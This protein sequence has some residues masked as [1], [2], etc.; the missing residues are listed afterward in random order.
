MRNL[1][2]GLDYEE[3][4]FCNSELIEHLEENGY[5]IFG[6]GIHSLDYGSQLMFDEIVKLFFVSDLLTREKIYKRVINKEAS[7]FHNYNRMDLFDYLDQMG[8]DFLDNIDS[9]EMISHLEMVGYKVI[10]E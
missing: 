7:T 8:F 9:Q 6:D 4:E 2:V 5:V 1:T 3:Y 10:P